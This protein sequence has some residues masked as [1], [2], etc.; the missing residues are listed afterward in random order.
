M[1]RV[2]LAIPLFDGHGSHRPAPRND[3]NASQD[4]PQLADQTPAYQRQCDHG[5]FTLY[6]SSLRNPKFS[7][8][9]MKSVH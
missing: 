4:W 7:T 8:S 3:S 2:D 5:T 1:D 6:A 9:P